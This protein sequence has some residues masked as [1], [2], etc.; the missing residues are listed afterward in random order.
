MFFFELG[1]AT[2][3]YSVNYE[4]LWL[5]STR[6]NISTRIG[7][8]YLPSASEQISFGFP[9][10]ISYLTK[11]KKNYFEVG[12][13]FV[14]LYEREVASLSSGSGNSFDKMNIPSIRLGIRRQPT[15]SGLFWNAL[16]QGS[17]VIVNPDNSDVG[18]GFFLPYASFG[19]GR[20][21]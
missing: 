3:I 5:K 13:S 20:A 10:G 21:F 1:G 18:I 7:V 15:E 9:V 11:M 12:A 19:I 2:F 14:S 17:L 4:H 6:S 16:L 8:M